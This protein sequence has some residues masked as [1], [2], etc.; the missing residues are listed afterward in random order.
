MVC[1]VNIGENKRSLGVG[2]VVGGGGQ[3][4]ELLDV[5]AG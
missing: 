2:V 5:K 4:T 1:F 3:G